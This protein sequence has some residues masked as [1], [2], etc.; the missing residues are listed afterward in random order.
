VKHFWLAMVLAAVAM[1]GCSASE[2]EHANVDSGDASSPVFEAQETLAECMQ[3]LGWEVQVLDDGRIDSTYP[4]SQKD[5][6][7]ADYDE[8][9]HLAGLG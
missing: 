2:G 3:D 5:E 6:F 9:K 7:V 4:T 1:T 8:C